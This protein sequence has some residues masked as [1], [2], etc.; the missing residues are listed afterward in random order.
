M[1]V[2]DWMT[3]HVSFVDPCTELSRAETIMDLENIEQVPIV[4]DNRVVG[5]LTK[6]D[7]DQFRSRFGTGNNEN[8]LV[9]AKFAMSENVIS[10]HPD[11]LIQEVC[12][13]FHNARIDA[14]PV[15]D[16]ENQLVGII[17]KVDIYEAFMSLLGIDDRGNTVSRSVP[18]LEKGLE[19]IR[20]ITRSDRVK[21]LMIYGDSGSEYVLEY[22]KS[23][24][25]VDPGSEEKRCS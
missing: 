14:A 17:T 21:C 13:L 11:D 2:E 1:K 24:E 15:V 12:G 3:E 20:K 19:N 6:N 5:M 10:V 8:R 23:N 18:D 4:D 25:D 22:R 9:P 7:I 16:D